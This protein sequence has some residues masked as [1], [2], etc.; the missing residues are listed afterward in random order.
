MATTSKH[1]VISRRSRRQADKCQ[2]SFQKHLHDVLIMLSSLYNDTIV[3]QSRID[4][5]C[6]IYDKMIAI[7]L[8]F[9]S[10]SLDSQ[11]VSLVSLLKLFRVSY[12]MVQPLIDESRQYNQNYK[13]YMD[14]LMVKSLKLYRNMYISEK[15]VRLYNAVL[16]SRVNIPSEVIKLVVSF[17]LFI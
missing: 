16:F 15:N 10:E 8:L 3:R 7:F 14:G 2:I 1:C 9:N 6:K 17:L 4:L 5:I 12:Q 13:K 11:N